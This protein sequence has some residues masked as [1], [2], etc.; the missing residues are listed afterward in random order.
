MHG[1]SGQKK[2]WEVIGVQQKQRM[3]RMRRGEILAALGFALPSLIGV[4][5][6]MII[7]AINSLYLS[8]TQYNVLQPPTFIGVENYR[9]MAR[10]PLFWKSLSN[11]LYMV[12][13]GVPPQLVTA[14]IIAL[15]LNVDVKGLAFYRAVYFLPSIVPTVAASVLWMWIL[16][17]R[18]GILNAALDKIGIVGPGWLT[19]TTWSKPSIILMLV[20][21]CGQTMIIYLAGLKG[22]PEHL[23]EA[24]LIDGANKWA[25][26]RYVTLPM[27][28]PTIFFTMVTALIGAFQIFTQA[29]ITTGG[30]PVNSTLFYVYYLFNNAFSFF[31]MGYASAL[32]WVL[33]GIIFVVTIIQFGLRKR[34]VYYEYDSEGDA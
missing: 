17:P 32:A 21:A 27:L 26:F 13:V 9:A 23:Y 11:T 12:V 19:S 34:W 15:L 6:F 16:N 22:I 2:L 28:T 25:S 8:F 18:L 20:W 1:R 33:F 30:G 3:S 29:F 14:L 4:I 10:D 7:P 31:K 5:V 24:A